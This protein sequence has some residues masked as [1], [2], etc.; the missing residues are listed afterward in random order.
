MSKEYPYDLWISV[1]SDAGISF[2]SVGHLPKDSS[3][4]Q[5]ILLSLQSLMTTEVNVSDSQFMTGQNEFVRFGSFTMPSEETNIVVQYIVRSE[6]ANS[7]SIEDESLVQELALSFGKFITLTPNFYDNVESGRTVSPDYVSKSFL[8]ACTIARQKI[9]IKENNSVFI[10]LINAHIEKAATQPDIFP[11]LLQMKNL[12]AWLKEEEQS[13]DKG[14]IN[15]FKRQLIIQMLSQDILNVISLENPFAILQYKK[16]RYAVDEISSRIENYL[17]KHSPNAEDLINEYLGKK[18]EKKINSIYS[19]LSISAIHSAETFIADELSKE[20]I[21]NIA[22]KQPLMGLIDFRDVKI[23]QKLQSMIKEKISTINQG[24]IICNALTEEA[25]PLI[26]QGARLFFNQLIS[27]FKER[28]LPPSVWSVICDFTFAIISEENIKSVKKSKKGGSTLNLKKE[29]IINKI[30]KLTNISKNLLKELTSIIENAGVGEKLQISNIEESVIFA[31]AL[32]RA[33]IS[34][35]V[36]IVEDQFFNSILGNIYLYIINSFKKIIPLYIFSSIVS[37]YIQDIRK[38]ELEIG[39][40]LSLTARDLIGG[41]INTGFL[42]A[43]IKSV[44]VVH[45]KSF[46][47]KIQL[48]FDKRTISVYE[49]LLKPG[50]TV[51]YDNSVFSLSQAESNAEILTACLIDHKILYA[52]YENSIIRKMMSSYPEKI[53]KFESDIV[54]KLDNLITLFQKERVSKLRNANL[55]PEIKE[56][57]PSFPEFKDVPENFANKNYHVSCYDIWNKNSSKVQKALQTLLSSFAQLR[58]NDIHYSEKAKKLYTSA[59]KELKKIRGK[60]IKSW[61]AVNKKIFSDIQHWVKSKIGTI[62]T[63]LDYIRKNY[64]KWIDDAFHYKK[65]QPNQFTPSV[66]ECKTKIDAIIKEVR[67]RELEELP[68]NFLEIALSILLY[69]RIPDYVIDDSYNQMIQDAKSAM[70]TVKRAWTKS[71]TR[72]EFETNLYINMRSLGN[73]LIKLINNYIRLIHDSFINRDLE[74]ST[75]RKGFYIDLGTIPKEIFTTKS[76]VTALYRFDNISVISG[77]KD[78]IVKCYIEPEYFKKMTKHLDRLVVISDIIR[79][80]ARYKFDE[81]TEPL[82]DGIKAA[83]NY[84]LE[85]G[86]KKVIDLIETMKEAIFRLSDYPSISAEEK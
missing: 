25:E 53:F 32:E 29:F 47:G 55:L 84:L 10:N 65:L 82:I 76:E 79:F 56:S 46:F 77:G 37:N 2:A 42:K 1:G 24:D 19:N 38:R 52:S 34:I 35:L 80:V 85:Q 58:S 72:K 14:T 30:Q 61:E 27:S 86:D 12:E 36:K 54:A 71:K 31:K 70:L 48:K 8:N 83:T 41:A 11:T 26:L 68:K 73:T 7:I 13:W 17:K 3:M 15:S 23:Y 18:V 62:D 50:L 9:S 16:P 4:M 64:E 78:W 5:G 21:L 75:D 81:M 63:H 22:K 60:I 20:I 66:E 40:Q 6:T 49:L 28:E 57:F 33:I 44:P 67:E 39:K 45:K 59:E 69:R 74:L 51:R 43:Y